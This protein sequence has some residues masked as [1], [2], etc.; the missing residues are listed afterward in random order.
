MNPLE[1]DNEASPVKELIMRPGAGWKHVGGP[2]WEHTNKTRVHIGGL[3]RLPNMTFVSDS[4]WPGSRTAAQLI[5][6]NGQ[7][8][9]RGLMAWAMTI[10]KNT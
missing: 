6:I 3:V 9:K 2:V 8:R 4:K 7:N 10:W 1:H 5:R